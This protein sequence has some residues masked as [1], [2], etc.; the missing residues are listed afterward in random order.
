M[1]VLYIA[2]GTCALAA[3]IL[4]RELQLPTRIEPVPLRTPDSPI[5][6]INPL[7]RVPALQLD[8]GTLITENTALLPYLADLRPDSGLFAAAGSAERAQIQS[9]LGY[10]AFEVHAGCFRPIFRPQRYSADEHAYPGIH[11]QTI[12]QLY[13]A[14]AHVDRHLQGRQHL[15]GERYSI[16]DLYLGMF[17]SWLPRLQSE[18]FADLDNLARVQQAFLARPA[19]RAALEFEAAR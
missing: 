17:V 18:R 9:W 15:V 8:D 12:E 14:L 1:S 13:Q 3:H 2:P 7:G 5:H 19:T 16:A 6:R 4:V 10:L 11:A